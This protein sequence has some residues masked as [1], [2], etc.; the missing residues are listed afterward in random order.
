MQGF[1]KETIITTLLIST[2]L[3]TRE[4]VQFKANTDFSIINDSKN[5]LLIQ[6]EN[7]MSSTS[8]GEEIILWEENFEN[9]NNGWITNSGWN[10]TDEDYNSET[11]S[12][13]S[14]N[15]QSTLDGTFNLLSP[16]LSLA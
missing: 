2:F 9:G 6:S 15:D 16:I 11:H 10:L 13:H 8:R 7:A 1:V 5:Y 14:P 3:F 12:M 4:K